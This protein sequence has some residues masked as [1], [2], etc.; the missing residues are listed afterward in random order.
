MLGI[1]ARTGGS[2]SHEP[3]TIGKAYTVLPDGC[4]DADSVM[5]ALLSGKATAEG[6]ARDVQA[7][8]RYGK[9]AI[10]EW[11]GRGMKRM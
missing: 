9:K 6:S 2:D 7:T 11:V 3:E 4:T 8:I 1:G 5:K 10:T